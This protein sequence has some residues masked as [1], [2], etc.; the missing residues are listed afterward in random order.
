MTALSLKLRSYVAPKHFYRKV[1]F[2]ALPI[3]IQHLLNNMMGVVD[4]IMVATIN[5]VTA[6]GTALQI[7]ML[8]LTITYGV[9]SGASIYIAQFFGAKDKKGQQ[10]AFG[11][12]LVLSLIVALVWFL[13]AWLFGEP[14]IR[15]YIQDPIVVANSLAYLNIAMYSYFPFAILMMFSF[16]YRS[17]QK[18]TIPMT[19]GIVSMAL[20]IIFNYLL[21]FGS[22]GFPQMGIA[23]AALGTLLAR[24][25][26]VLMYLFYAIKNKETF[27]GSPREIFT[28]NKHQ[29]TVMAARTYPLMINEFFFGLGSTIFIRFY[30][31][32]GTQA[33]DSYYVAFKLSQM[34]MFVVM[35]VNAA[36][37]AILGADLGK[38]D[39]NQAK[40]NAHH[41]IGLG[42]VLS[43][44]MIAIIMVLAPSLVGLYRLDDPLI[45]SS[46]V[47]IVRFFA[48][49]LALRMFNV[50]IFSSLR[51]GGDAR[52]LTFLDAGILWLIGLPLAYVLVYVLKMDDL[53]M[54]LLIVQLEQIIRLFIGSV[55]V[56]QGSWLKNLTH[57]LA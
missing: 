4:S 22:F 5:Q 25:I 18:T 31:T 35:G 14:I 46:A 41:F 28:L 1:A 30:G 50:M 2:I 47:L 36:T 26:G 44:S 40:E 53:P 38:G 37:A 6:V 42:L 27:I 55:R 21:I 12:G 8:V 49:R 17:I 16:A 11:F 54:I 33:M 57:E 23:G 39:L 43:L 9:A 7:E 3:T 32:L 20:N 10:K 24:I 34:F 19:I 45:I 48:L 51:A 56:K 29:Y 52:F 13:L 15:F